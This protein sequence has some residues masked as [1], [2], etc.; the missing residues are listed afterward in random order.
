[1]ASRSKT[2]TY[3]N[4]DTDINGNFTGTNGTKNTVSTPYLKQDAATIWGT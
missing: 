4:V 3:G 1:M 2:E